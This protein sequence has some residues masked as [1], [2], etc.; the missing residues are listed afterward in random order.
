MEEDELGE[1]IIKAKE[2]LGNVI[3]GHTT[4]SQ[5]TIPNKW[6]DSEGT[7]YWDCPGFNDTKGV[8]QDVSNGYYIKTLFENINQVKTVVIVSH[9]TLIGR[10]KLFVDIIKKVA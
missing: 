4:D 6:V 3:I 2:P 1:L 7:V 10:A 9:P 8:E 5:T